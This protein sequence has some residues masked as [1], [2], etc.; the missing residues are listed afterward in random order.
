[1]TGKFIEAFKKAKVTPIYKKGNPLLLQNYRPISLLSAFSKILEKAVHTRMLS[2]LNR[3]KT[4]SKFQLDFRPNHSTSAACNCLVNKITK[5]FGNN[6]I[7]LT[8]F[9]DLSKAFDELDHQI[10]LNKLYQYGFRGLSHAWLTS[11]LANRSQR[12]YIH[13]KLSAVTLIDACAPQGSNLGPLLFLIYVN[14]LFLNTTAEIIVYA[15]DMT[16][17]VPGKSRADVV[18]IAREQLVRVFIW[19]TNNKLIVNTAKTKFMIF[20]PKSHNTKNQL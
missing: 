10:L 8:V 18:G 16:L 7:A 2:Y 15:D 19:L 3:C 5:H 13:G 1:M 20:F 11:H 9:L 14:D 12:V 6:K 17:I 4:L